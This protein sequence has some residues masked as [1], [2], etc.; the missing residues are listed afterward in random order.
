MASAWKCLDENLSICI[1][2]NTFLEQYFYC[3]Y[4]IFIFMIFL[5][6]IDI[7]I[8][9]YYINFL[10]GRDNIIWE[11]SYQEG[12]GGTD[13][14]KAGR[15][16][17]MCA[18]SPEGQPYPGLHQKQHG[19]QVER[20]DSAL[21][22]CSGETPPGVL[23]PALEPSAQERHGAVGAGPEEGHKNDQRAGTPLRWGKAERFGAVHPAEE[24]VLGRPYC[25]LSLPK[26]G[27]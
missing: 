19:Q 7:Y 9:Y 27:L 22:R 13:I 18:H 2:Q 4:F 5:D 25:G 10:F 17:T 16:P 23:N 3:I 11:Q 21:L 1:P 20:G 12:L 15:E 26:E 6:I 14:S 24:K 8:Y